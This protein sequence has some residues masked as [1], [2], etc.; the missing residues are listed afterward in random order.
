MMYVQCLLTRE[1]S[2]MVSWIGDKFATKGKVL[3]FKQNGIWD[4]GWKVE[5]TYGRQSAED[6]V[7]NSQLYK[8]HRK[9]T[10]IWFMTLNYIYLLSTVNKFRR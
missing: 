4:R 7:S 9:G 2:Q 8:Q 5:Q 3:D 1:S 6:T 10:D